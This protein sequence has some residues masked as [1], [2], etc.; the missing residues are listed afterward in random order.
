MHAASGAFTIKAY[1]CLLNHF[2]VLPPTSNKLPDAL[3]TT[4][5]HAA[6]HAAWPLFDAVGASR[7]A[8]FPCGCCLQLRMTYHP[9]YTKGSCCQVATYYAKDVTFP[10]HAGY[11]HYSASYCADP[12]SHIQKSQQAD[13]QQQ[14]CR[15]SRM[16][17]RDCL[18]HD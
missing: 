7:Y 6:V 5:P 2:A 15:S 3:T 14:V 11:C 9:L 12:A 17:P 16:G 10:G 1:S 4:A 13:P 18:R 8:A